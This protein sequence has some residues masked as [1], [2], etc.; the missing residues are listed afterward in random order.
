MNI[1]L[2]DHPI[3]WEQ[4]LPL[5]FTRPI[6]EMRI[7][8][9]TITEK[10]KRHAETNQVSWITENYLT[11]KYKSQANSDTFFVASHILPS[12]KLMKKIGQL[13]MGEILKH[14]DKIIALRGTVSDFD[15][16]I[17]NN[18]ISTKAVHKFTDPIILITRP[19]DVF[20][21]NGEE[22]VKDI[23]L[24]K[25]STKFYPLDDKHSA[26]YKSSDIYIEEG[27]KVRAAILNA[28]DGPIYLGRNSQVQEGG[29]IKGPF[30]LCD[31]SIVNMGGKMRPFTTIGPYSKVGGEVSNAVFFGYSNKGHDGFLGNAVIGEWCNLG[32]D[33]NASNMKNNY[34]EVKMWNYTTKEFEKTGK[35]FCGLIMG[36]HSKAGINTM[37]NTGTSVG[38]SCNIFDGKFP[39]TFIPSF[40]WGGEKSWK[41]FRLE[42]ALET[43]NRVLLRRNMVLSEA[44]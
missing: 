6:G 23:E 9:F 39:P 20:A 24:L 3:I 4:L 41:P 7:G 27:V 15:K 13:G 8:V 17:K 29:I 44:E 12:E 40:S 35:Q 16:Q 33:T 11:V 30:A 1:V 31:G 5:T 2:F 14:E 42:Q 37:F 34:S 18:H 36:D 19:Y 28:E 10:W 26:T 38:V 43:A 21:H 32:A 25:K 22:L